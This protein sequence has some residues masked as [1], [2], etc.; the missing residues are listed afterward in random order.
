MYPTIR[1]R[2]RNSGNFVTQKLY[3]YIRL[4]GLIATAFSTNV[5]CLYKFD[6]K[7]QTFVG[8]K[9]EVSTLNDSLTE[10]RTE[11]RAVYNKMNLLKDT[12]TAQMLRDMYL[13]EK[14][15]NAIVIPTTLQCFEKY[16][17][18][19]RETE[20][21][22]ESTLAKIEYSKEHFANFTNEQYKRKDF[23]LRAITSTVATNFFDYMQKQVNQKGDLLSYEHCYRTLQHLVKTVDFAVSKK[24]LYSNPLTEIG[25]KNKTEE[26]KIV[27]L[28]ERDVYKLIASEG[29]SKTERKVLDGFIIMC[30]TGLRHSDYVRFLQNPKQYIFKDDTNFE[31]IELYSYKNRKDEAQAS[32]YV[33]LH[34]IVKNILEHY[35][36]NLPS[37][38]D[39][40]ISRYM[41]VITA[42]A[43]VFHPKLTTYVARKTTAC[44]FG[45]MDGIEIK[46]ISK[47][48]GH[49][50]V[51]T[52][53]KY[54]FRVNTETVKRQ[55]L[56]A[57]SK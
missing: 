14:R 42:R 46:A 48:L 32:S 36:Y 9:K 47:M 8:S 15:A 16:I 10:I 55:Y 43:E 57:M 11:I 39:Q 35:D 23:E 49:K 4:N 52:T 20:N 45:N 3:C 26:S 22:E 6:V 18:H 25:I 29:L 27:P 51:S 33:P 21:L 2:P 40:I 30:F 5:E 54:Y 24:F 44:L 53:E 56:R 28:S 1:F 12:F 19:R 50:R 7:K 37:Y 13:S 38:S 41:K 34:P 31:Y 17:E